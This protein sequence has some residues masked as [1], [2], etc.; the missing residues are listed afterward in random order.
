MRR[1][2][3]LRVLRSS[4]VISGVVRRRHG[5]IGSCRL[6]RNLG[7]DVACLG[8]VVIV[9][10]KVLADQSFHVEPARSEDAFEIYRTEA[11][12]YL[13]LVIKL[14]NVHLWNVL[15]RLLGN[16]TIGFSSFFRRD[17]LGKNR[18]TLPSR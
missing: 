5:D 16:Q 13:P 17:F 3:V 18:C 8:V 6:G 12:W 10:V 15:L 4:F 7:S 9:V 2:F 11:H 1:A 14:R